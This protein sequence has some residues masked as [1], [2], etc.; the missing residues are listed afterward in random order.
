MSFL[1]VEICISVRANRD[2]TRINENDVLVS[3]ELGSRKEQGPHLCDF[4][5][6][7]LPVQAPHPRN[8]YPAKINNRAKRDCEKTQ[9]KTRIAPR[10]H[11][12][13]GEVSRLKRK[14]G[15]HD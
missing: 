2:V 7:H 10:R 14:E 4:G 6:K 13:E 1:L 8:R 15:L 3:G 12:E 5:E 9:G 11:R